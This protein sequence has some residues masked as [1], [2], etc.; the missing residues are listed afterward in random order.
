M[1]DESDGETQDKEGTF[2]YIYLNYL[3]KKSSQEECKLWL[4]SFQNFYFNSY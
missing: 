2:Y 4:G 1:K 3:G